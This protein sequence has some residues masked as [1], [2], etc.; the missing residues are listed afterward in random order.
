MS[1]GGF[2]L[3][4]SDQ[5]SFVFYVFFVFFGIGGLSKVCFFYGGDR[6]LEGLF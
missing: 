4:Y 1:W 2:V 6:G 5:V 3:D